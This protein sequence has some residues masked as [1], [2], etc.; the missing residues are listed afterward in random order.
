M[1]TFGVVGLL[2]DLTT[3]NKSGFP[4]FITK[5]GGLSRPV[6]IEFGP[7]GAM[8]ILDMGINTIDNLSYYYPKTGVIWKV[9]KS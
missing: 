6:D 3:I 8:Y 7:D 2:L 4:S 1:V 9:T 5:Q